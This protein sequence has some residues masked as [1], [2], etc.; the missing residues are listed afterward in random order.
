MNS[1]STLLRI[2]SIKTETVD[3]KSFTLETVDGKP[4]VYKPG[5]FLTLLFK[6][7]NGDEVRRSYSISSST[8]LEEPLTI[9]IKKIPNG[10]FSRKMVDQ[11][12]EGNLLNSIG[13][14]G[15]FT[16]PDSYPAHQRFCF[17]AAGSGITPIFAQIKS[18]LY[19]SA[20][21]VI[22]IYSNRSASSTIFLDEIL[23][24]KD[25]FKDQLMLELLFSESAILTQSRLTQGVLDQLAQKHALYKDDDTLFYLCGPSA[26]MRMINIKLRAEG[27]SPESIKKELFLVEAPTHKLAEPPDTD[28][29]SVTIYYNNRSFTIEVQYPESILATAKKQGEQLPYS[30]ETGQCGTC[31]AICTS[32]KV[33]MRYNEVLGKKALTDGYILTCTGYPIDGPVTLKL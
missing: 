24:L 16:L 7:S 19:G 12:R 14:A 25:Q 27:I 22:L 30:C 23:Q 11:A 13:A 33:W 9:T 32:G 20:N 31:A 8:T 4:L 3:T 21:R 26:Y 17:L 18:I 1:L 2:T 5:Q 15:L 29:H 6:H 28:R 10:E